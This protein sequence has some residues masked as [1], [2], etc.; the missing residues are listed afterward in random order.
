MQYVRLPLRDGLRGGAHFLARGATRWRRPHASAQRR[1]HWRHHVG[2]EERTATTLTRDS[3]LRP[4]CLL[5]LPRA[6]SRQSRVRRWLNGPLTQPAAGP[7]PPTLGPL[8]LH[9]PRTARTFLIGQG[10]VGEVPACGSVL[11]ARG[12]GGHVATRPGL[13]W[14]AARFPCLRAASAATHKPSFQPQTPPSH[15]LE[16]KRAPRVHPHLVYA[17]QRTVE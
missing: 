8:V 5:R 6:R 10:W 1:T 15:T 13:S 14:R 3:D 12:T 11:E 7:R 4:H 9:T 17:Q 16:N 2:Q